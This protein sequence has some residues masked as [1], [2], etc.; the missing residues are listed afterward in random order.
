M[1]SPIESSRVHGAAGIVMMWLQA[2]RACCIYSRVQLESRLIL[3]C[4]VPQPRCAGCFLPVPC[5]GLSSFLR[6]RPC[7]SVVL[8]LFIVWSDAISFAGALRDL[9]FRQ[10]MT[11]VLTCVAVASTPGHPW[12]L[13]LPVLL[14]AISSSRHWLRAGTFL[15][16][17]RCGYTCITQSAHAWRI[18]YCF[19]A[20]PA[21]LAAVASSP[22]LLRAPLE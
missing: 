2:T 5:R 17:S 21:F 7:V 8:S 15:A 1:L 6:C 14:A 18:D 20:A 19:L 11:C 12:S 16:R 9:F 3:A 22:R 13:R 4:H 10:Y